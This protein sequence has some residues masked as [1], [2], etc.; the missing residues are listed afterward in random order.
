MS[1]VQTHK[2]RIHR[3]NAPLAAPPGTLNPVCNLTSERRPF[4]SSIR[5]LDILGLKSSKND[6]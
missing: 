5:L 4:G 2:P 3:P 1:S 6:V